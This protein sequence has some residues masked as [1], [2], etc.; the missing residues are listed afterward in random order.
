MTSDPMTATTAERAGD[1]PRARPYR[2]ARRG[3]DRAPTPEPRRHRV[4]GVGLGDRPDRD[5]PWERLLQ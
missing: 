5:P 4:A 1:P 2:A 3:G